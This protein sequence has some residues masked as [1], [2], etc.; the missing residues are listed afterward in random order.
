MI[1]EVFTYT[2]K[3]GSIAQYEEIFAAALPHRERFSKLGAFWHTEIGPLN[4]AIH[5]WPYESIEER[6]SIREQVRNSIR[7][8]AGKD[9]NW[10]PAYDPD[11][12]VIT[13]SEI[14]IPAPFM[15]PLGGDQALGNFYEM[16]SY[17]YKR[18]SIGKVIDIWADAIPYR[19]KHSPLAA[20][21][22]A[23]IGGL[24][25]WIHIWPYNDMEQ[26]DRIRAEASKSLHWPPPTREWLVNQE[27]KIMVPSA[28]SPMH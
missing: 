2:L 25:K 24:N 4:Q 5:I 7:E 11:I 22:Y 26:R 15:R 10:P 18:G 12:F 3:P 1:Y 14:L 8:E 27:T 9:P 21:M 6:T 13:N 19:E 28:F 23:D 20:A 16:R 17:T